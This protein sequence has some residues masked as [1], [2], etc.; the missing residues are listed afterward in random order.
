MRESSQGLT[1]LEASGQPQ[2]DVEIKVENIGSERV[3]RVELIAIPSTL[4]KSYR[5]I[6]LNPI[7]KDIVVQVAPEYQ[8]ISSSPIVITQRNEIFRLVSRVLDA[9]TDLR[10]LDLINFGIEVVVEEHDPLKVDLQNDPHN[11]QKLI[12]L[13]RAAG[14]S[15]L[16]PK[17][18]HIL[19]P[20]DKHDQ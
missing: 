16:L 13:Y 17:V 14:L 8:E 7:S 9:E 10:E 3:S 19:R 6:A 11:F 15:A 20:I 2:N 18:M 4:I 5:G 1:I 12:E